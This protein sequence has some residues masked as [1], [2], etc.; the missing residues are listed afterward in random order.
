MRCPPP[1]GARLERRPGRRGGTTWWRGRRGRSLEETVPVRGGVP[2]SVRPSR[3][4][5]RQRS[6]A[7]LARTR[8]RRQRQRRGTAQRP[9]GVAAQG[10]L[11]LGGNTESERSP[12][13]GPGRATHTAPGAP[14]HPAWSGSR[15][16][17]S[18]AGSGQPVPRPRH[19][20]RGVFRPDIQCKCSLF[21]FKAV[22][23][24]LIPVRLGKKS[25]SLFLNTPTAKATPEFTFSRY[26]MRM[27]PHKQ[28][29]RQGSNV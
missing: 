18:S 17:A 20:P 14:S 24:S 3:Y 16:G 23:P 11:G 19:A 25:L 12:R 27:A 28:V 15:D 8:R 9:R 7:G 4:R 1:V 6:P 26:W 2:V 22:P 21:Q 29:R 5:A 13:A 10:M